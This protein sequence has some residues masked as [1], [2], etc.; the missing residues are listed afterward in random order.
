M[1]ENLIHLL[2]KRN[3]E[4]YASTQAVM[5]ANKNLEAAREKYKFAVA[6][7]LYDRIEA[8][9]MT[10]QGWKCGDMPKTYVIEIAFENS[11]FA[12]EEIEEFLQ[13]FS[14]SLGYVTL[15]Y[16]KAYTVTAEVKISSC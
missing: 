7:N 15:K 12:P 16:N 3:D 5:K 2:Q 14:K 11:L 4:F 6:Q 8:A 10:T 1:A 9:M 13:R